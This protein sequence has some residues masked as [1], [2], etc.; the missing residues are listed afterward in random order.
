MPKIS[1]DE[2][3]DTTNSGTS[4]PRLEAGGYVCA[5]QRMELYADKKYC[6]LIYDIVEGEH[7]GKYSDP[8]FDDKDYAHCVYLS[9]KDTALGM[10]KHRLTAID[11]SNAGFD[12]FA[13]WDADKWALFTGKQFGI[14]LR[15]EEYEKNDGTIGTRLRESD[16]VPAEKIHSGDFTVPKPKKLKRAE[17]AVAMPYDE[18]I[19][20]S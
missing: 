16:M 19:P 18:E 9:Y 4:Y 11:D 10:L 20:F 17:S 14:I 6:K 7:A 8:Y 2:I 15:E 5:I 13:A 1:W 12:A 3:E